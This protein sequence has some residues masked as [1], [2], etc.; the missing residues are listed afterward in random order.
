[1]GNHTCWWQLT[2]QLT[3][4]QLLYDLCLCNTRFTTLFDLPNN[5]Y[6][7][8]SSIPDQPGDRARRL[9]SLEE[10]RPV[11]KSQV[12]VLIFGALV[13]RL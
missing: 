13:L 1:L 5:L 12:L 4:F 11:W 8:E 3:D 2:T 9:A 10:L 6:S 7:G